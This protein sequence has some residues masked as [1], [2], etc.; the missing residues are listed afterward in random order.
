MSALAFLSGLSFSSGTWSHFSIKHTQLFP[1]A[2]PAQTTINIS[3][4][5]KILM[6]LVPSIFSRSNQSVSSLVNSVKRQ[7]SL[8]EA[9]CQLPQDLLCI[10]PISRRF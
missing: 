6:F 4:D 9:P 5:S 8:H 1:T 7:N 10:C 2:L 3:L